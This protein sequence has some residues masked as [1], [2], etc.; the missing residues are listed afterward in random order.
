VKRSHRIVNVGKTQRRHI[1]VLSGDSLNGTIYDQS[2]EKRLLQITFLQ[3]VAANAEL[4]ITGGHPFETARLYW[5]ADHWEME[6]VAMV[7]AVPE[8][9]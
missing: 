9:R 7:D 5:N 4:H 3:E 1:T 2:T 8:G 6:L